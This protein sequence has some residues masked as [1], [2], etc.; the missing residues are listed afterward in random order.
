MIEKSVNIIVL[1]WNQKKLSLDC[2]KSLERA[3]YQNKHIVFVD[4]GSDDG[5]ANAVQNYYP[6]VEIIRSEKNLGYAKGN[7]FGFKSTI[8]QAVY[9]IFLN[10]DTFVD[11][12]FIEPLINQLEEEPNTIQVVPKIYFADNKDSIWYA[13]GNANLA[14]AQINHRGIRSKDHEKYN[15]IKEVD[16]ATGC[17]FCM[18]TSDFISLGMFDENFQMYGEDVDLSLKARNS[19]GI[20]T[21]VPKSQIWHHVS[22]SIGGK[23]SFSKWKRKFR[24]IYKL[25][26]KYSNPLF[27]PL[28][29]LLLLL[30]AVSSFIILSLLKIFR[31][32]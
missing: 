22:S 7:N 13:G 15:L 30:N 16:Y 27:F 11:P 21:Y 23:Y 31:I 1:N 10:N 14:F 20:I 18:R 26:L 28:T 25:I 12:S 6:N 29:F 3:T 9:T 5:S 32:K 24:S 2:L 19:G 8:Q 4:N 17:C